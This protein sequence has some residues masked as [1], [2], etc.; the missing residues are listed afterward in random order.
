[1]SIEVLKNPDK[2]HE[3]LDDLESSF[4]TFLYAALHRF[5]H[6]SKFN[7]DV[8]TYHKPEYEN[9]APTG[10]ELGGNEKQEALRD[11]SKTVQF[12]C[13]PLQKLIKKLAAALDDYHTSSA[14]MISKKSLLEDDPEDARAKRLYDVAL[15]TRNELYTELSDPSWWIQQF[16]DALE[17]PGWIDDVA[18]REIYPERTQ[19]QEAQLFEI[20]SRTS[21]SHSLCAT[22]NVNTASAPVPPQANAFHSTDGARGFGLSPT[23][24]RNR[25]FDDVQI[26]PFHTIATSSPYADSA[27][28]EDPPSSPSFRTANRLKRTLESKED[29]DS[30]K[31]L[32]S[33]SGLPNYGQPLPEIKRESRVASSSSGGPSRSRKNSKRSSTKGK[34][35]GVDRH[36]NKSTDV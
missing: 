16:K 5:E 6:K 1:M 28:N 32:R 13:K 31:R 2:L 9:G 35:K 29:D 36:I 26:H 34:G 18:T 27:N 4:W 17:K 8:F 15:V 12:S 24:R 22:S 20:N 14:T 11:L 10:R 7:M 3:I 25:N 33:I 30:T 23:S 19:K 21:Y